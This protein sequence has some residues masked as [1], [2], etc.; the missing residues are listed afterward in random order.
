MR[1]VLN[2]SEDVAVPTRA[3]AKTSGDGRCPLVEA[4]T[5][6]PSSYIYIASHCTLETTDLG[7]TWT[8]VDYLDDAPWFAVATTTTGKNI[9][10]IADGIYLSTNYGQSWHRSG[11]APNF[12]VNSYYHAVAMN[13]DGQ[14]I[15]LAVVG[16]PILLS[17]DYGLTWRNCTGKHITSICVWTCP[18]NALPLLYN[19]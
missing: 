10:A 18:L 15:G 11:N 1:D 16:G 13:A 5:V 8:K 9:T 19:F 4:A 2:L 3:I 17:S 12:T 6:D 14:Y 7:G